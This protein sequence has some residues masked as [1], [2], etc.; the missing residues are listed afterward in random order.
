MSSENL[1]KIIPG[2]SYVWILKVRCTHC[3]QESEKE[4]YISA[5]DVKQAMSGSRGTSTSVSTC[6]FCKR[7]GSLDVIGSSV[8]EYDCLLA[9]SDPKKAFQPMISLDCRGIEPILC[10]PSESQVQVVA[11]DS[12]NC[13]EASLNEEWA[14]FDEDTQNSLAI[15][16]VESKIEKTK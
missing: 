11:L 2:K 1:C 15:Y 5:E 4:L 6:K 12:E 16:K 14:E 9:Q 3:N 7:E 8:A 10:S 13:F